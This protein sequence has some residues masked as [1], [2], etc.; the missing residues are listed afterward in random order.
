[1]APGVKCVVFSRHE[2]ARAAVPAGYASMQELKRILRELSD[3]VDRISK[4]NL[5]LERQL[6]SITGALKGVVRARQTVSGRTSHARRDGRSGRRGAPA[7][8]DDTQAA[9]LRKEYERGATAGKLARRY[10]AALPTILSTL[11]RAGTQLRRG[12]PRRKR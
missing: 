11:R 8:F 2:N 5:F 7:K 6:Q 10:R 1:M 4:R 3:E 12:R 9:R